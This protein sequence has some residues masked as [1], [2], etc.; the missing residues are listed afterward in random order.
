MGP[1]D[2]CSQL[3]ELGRIRRETRWPGYLGIG[4]YHAGAYE[5]DWVSAYTKAAE[6]WTAR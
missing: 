2:K 4:D 3:R 1:T 6:M 5:C